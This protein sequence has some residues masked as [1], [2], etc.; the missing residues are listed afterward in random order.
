MPIS[1][2][3]KLKLTTAENDRIVRFEVKLLAETLTTRYIRPTLVF[4][5]TK[6]MI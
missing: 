1:V 3:S 5:V 4:G 6:N 2:P